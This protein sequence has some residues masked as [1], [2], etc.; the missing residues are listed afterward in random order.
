[1]WLAEFDIS[2]D[3]HILILEK[4]KKQKLDILGSS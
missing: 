1:M 2:V 3:N 4:A